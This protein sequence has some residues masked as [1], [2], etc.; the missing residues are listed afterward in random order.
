[1]LI[2]GEVSVVQLDHV[3]QV[4]PA[5]KDVLIHPGQVVVAKVHLLQ[6]R[7]LGH[8]SAER[9]VWS[10]ME[11]MFDNVLNSKFIKKKLV[12]RIMTAF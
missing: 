4:D 12:R 6:A 2:P 10:D 7:L 8:Q 1:M 9:R 3:D 5:G 11:A